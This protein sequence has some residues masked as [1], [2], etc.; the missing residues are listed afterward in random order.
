M[1]QD[2]TNSRIQI[3]GNYGGELM[4]CAIQFSCSAGRVTNHNNTLGSTANEDANDDE[5]KEEVKCEMDDGGDRGGSKK[6][7]DDAFQ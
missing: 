5:G 4:N 3:S 6:T 2:A 1:Y 7:S